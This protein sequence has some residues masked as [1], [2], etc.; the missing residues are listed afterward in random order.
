MKKVPTNSSNIVHEERKRFKKHSCDICEKKFFQMPAL[1]MH[2]IVVH[3]RLKV[4]KCDLCEKSYKHYSALK[5]HVKLFHRTKVY[6]CEKSEKEFVENSK[7]KQHKKE[8]HENN[9][10]KESISET[11][12]KEEIQ[13]ANED[14]ST[15]DKYFED[16]QL[17]TYTSYR[18]SKM[19]WGHFKELPCLC[20]WCQAFPPIIFMVEKCVYFDIWNKFHFFKGS[21]L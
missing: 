4:F 19:D 9:L 5:D 15:N 17:G 16:L 10:D 14:S 1:E 18:V 11:N 3:L 20:F 12:F 2:I 21:S 6:T 13:E 8:H 7:L